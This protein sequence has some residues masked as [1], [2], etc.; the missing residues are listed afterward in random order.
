MEEQLLKDFL[1]TAKN[2]NYDWNVVMAKFPELADVDLQLLK[3]YAETA[4]QNNYD[5]GVVNAKFPELFGEKKEVQPKVK[6]IKKKDS[7]GSSSEDG[8]LDLRN[9][10]DKGVSPIPSLDELQVGDD[11]RDT[12]PFKGVEA[13][14]ENGIF[15]QVP[16]LDR[17]K[18]II[19]PDEKVKEVT[20]E[21]TYI[22]TAEKE[23]AL[24]EK[25][26]ALD[27]KYNKENPTLP[28]FD[29][30][31]APQTESTVIADDVMR[32][33][34]REILIDQGAP[35]T[36]EEQVARD[37]SMSKRKE[38][39]AI[40]VSKIKKARESLLNS[41]DYKEDLNSVRP[42]VFRRD[43]KG[44]VSEMNKRFGKYGLV[45]SDGFG[46]K[47]IVQ[48]SATGKSVA[49]NFGQ[50][51]GDF[52]ESSHKELTTFINAN[53]VAPNS[54]I[55]P[56][57]RAV[58]KAARVHQLRD[59]GRI[60][61]EEGGKTSTVLMQSANFDGVEVAYPTL[62]PKNPETHQIGWN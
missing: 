4:K 31:S 22:P 49:L 44:V 56:F 29:I 54:N 19:L 27:E 59:V 15:E 52:R 16:E 40:E 41:E 5:Y 12:Q 53:A 26:A 3:D 30:Y 45:F 61:E 55:A 13:V 47:M 43:E 36:Y 33:V 10:S 60:S 11:M 8:S 23:A 50:L 28:E 37:E 24:I 7:T 2:D 17:S 39:E 38:K 1:E 51:D 21:F 25:E 14:S 57:E 46:D 34:S 48:S 18:P 6:D 62:F 42:E 35:I 32:K 9:L 20:S 58:I